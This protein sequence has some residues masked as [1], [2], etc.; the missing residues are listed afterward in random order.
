MGDVER[1]QGHRAIAYCGQF[2]S[3][4]S[5]NKYKGYMQGLEQSGIV[6]DPARVAKVEQAEDD[7]V[8]A[9]AAALAKRRPSARRTPHYCGG[10]GVL[11][12]VAS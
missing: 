7:A 4:A 3:P 12:R 6:Y 9:A 8:Q 5:M 1:G 11:A 2:T 10:A